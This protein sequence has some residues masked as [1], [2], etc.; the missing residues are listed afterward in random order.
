MRSK[1][2]FGFKAQA[3]LI[4]GLLLL[5]LGVSQ[6]RIA[7]AFPML[8][9]AVEVTSIKAVDPAQLTGP[10][11]IQARRV[12]ASVDTALYDEADH[13]DKCSDASL[14][15]GNC[16]KPSPDR[17]ALILQGVKRSFTVP[18][19]DR[20]SQHI[21]TLNASRINLAWSLASAINEKSLQNKLYPKFLITARIRI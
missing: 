16:C 7:H 6:S 14:P 13:S 12:S 5:G 15:C 4:A 21:S 8:S 20:A 3:G 18:A 11:S 9:Q 17:Y 2:H 10:A 1:S 19:P